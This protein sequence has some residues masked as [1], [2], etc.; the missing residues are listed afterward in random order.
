IAD[1]QPGH[2]E[3]VI[4]LGFFHHL[5]E[6]TLPRAYSASENFAKLCAIRPRKSG[7][8]CAILRGRAVSCA[9]AGASITRTPV[10]AAAVYSESSPNWRRCILTSSNAAHLL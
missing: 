8:S 3:D 4:D 6:Q 9:L 10:V 1:T 2:Q 5:P 7:G